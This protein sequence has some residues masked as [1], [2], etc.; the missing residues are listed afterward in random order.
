MVI[1]VLSWKIIAA[2][3]KYAIIP[4]KPIHVVSFPCSPSIVIRK[5]SLKWRMIVPIRRTVLGKSRPLYAMYNFMTEHIYQYIIWLADWLICTTWMNPV[6]RYVS[7][8]LLKL[9]TILLYARTRCTQII[10]VWKQANASI[11]KG[12]MQITRLQEMK[13]EIDKYISPPV[14]SSSYP[15][16]YN[17]LINGCDRNNIYRLLPP[18]CLHGVC[19]VICIIGNVEPQNCVIIICHWLLALF[20]VTTTLLW[21]FVNQYKFYNN[22]INGW[23]DNR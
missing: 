12:Y 8:L 19:Q 6:Q 23:S 18:I 20:E 2:G 11:A 15:N 9:F 22:Q 16:L 5:E 14:A 7:G 4:T 17:N 1:S 10:G 21:Q 3:M 13:Y